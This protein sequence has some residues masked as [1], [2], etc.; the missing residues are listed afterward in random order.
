M[1]ELKVAGQ[2]KHVGF[3]STR[4]AGTDGVS[5]EIGKWA[6]V[7][8]SFGLKCFYFAGELDRSP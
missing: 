1:D 6:H 2:I 4:I 7:M 5:L 3:I 8:E